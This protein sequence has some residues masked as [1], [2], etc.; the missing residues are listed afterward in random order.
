MNWK[1]RLY[2]DS[3]VFIKF[4]LECAYSAQLISELYGL[5]LLLLFIMYVLFIYVFITKLTG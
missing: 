5:L 4:C 1:D 2:I 3:T